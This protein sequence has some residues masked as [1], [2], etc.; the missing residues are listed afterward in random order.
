MVSL[1]T[2][3]VKIYH[4]TFLVTI[5]G[6]YNAQMVDVLNWVAVGTT[7]ALFVLSCFALVLS[8][9]DK[10]NFALSIQ[11]V[12]STH[13]M[14]SLLVYF[15]SFAM[16]L[17]N[18]TI[19]YLFTGSYR[20]YYFLLLDFADGFNTKEN[21][22]LSIFA[23]ASSF[24]IKCIVFVVGMILWRSISNANARGALL[25]CGI[26][27]YFSLLASLLLRFKNTCEECGG[28]VYIVGVLV[29]LAALGTLFYLNF[30]VW[31]TISRHQHYFESDSDYETNIFIEAQPPVWFAWLS[32]VLSVA[33]HPPSVIVSAFFS[34]LCSESDRS[35]ARLPPISDI[36]AVS[37]P[38]KYR[39]VFALFLI[40]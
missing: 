1:S 26:W 30:R 35:R 14:K 20:L 13:T 31:R 24:V 15:Q 27:L 9:A 8:I 3:Q 25:Q 17:T 18:T 38:G 29:S 21:L 7:V 16:L 22:I 12:I 32:K 37:K 40:N 19:H 23:D 36:R 5:P 33:C 11:H 10:D 28:T 2:L 34:K 4:V 39:K 6:K